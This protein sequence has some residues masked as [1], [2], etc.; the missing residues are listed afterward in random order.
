MT[1]AVYTLLAQSRVGRTGY[2]LTGATR[3]TWS[4]KFPA[5]ATTKFALQRI[6]RPPLR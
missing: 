6:L 1:P 5:Y 3:K 4:D 2:K